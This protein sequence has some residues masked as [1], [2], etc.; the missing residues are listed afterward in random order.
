MISSFSTTVASAAGISPGGQRSAV[1]E[2][3]FALCADV[4]SGSICCIRFVGA[5][6]EGSLTGFLLLPGTTNVTT[7]TG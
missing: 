7:G 5:G 4:L 6:A 3:D 1:G 2:R